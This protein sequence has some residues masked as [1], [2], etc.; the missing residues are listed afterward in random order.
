MR[1]IIKQIA[2]ALRNRVRKSIDNT[3]CTGASVRLHGNE[4]AR[5]T[6]EGKLEVSLAGWPTVT[7]RERVNGILAEFGCEGRIF[8]HKGEQMFGGRAISSTEWIVI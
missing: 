1:N 3:L 6:D 2:I 8:Q 5:I 7:T 4:I